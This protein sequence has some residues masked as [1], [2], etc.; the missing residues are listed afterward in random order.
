MNKL[1]NEQITESDFFEAH[2]DWEVPI[3]GFFIIAPKRPCRSITDFTDEEAIDCIQLMRR[4]RR[5][6]AEVLHITDVYIFQNEDS[7]HGFH[8]WLFPR[9][10]WMDQF[11]RKIE[12]I[13]LIEQHAKTQLTDE[14]HMQEVRDAASR[15][16]DFLV[17]A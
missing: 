2:Q 17:S 5:A 4:V 15:V 11:G 9:H 10:E 6:M 12:S 14:S 16:R 1:F 7:V 13:R 3:V 8:V